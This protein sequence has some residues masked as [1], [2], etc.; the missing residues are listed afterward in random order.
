MFA[1]AIRDID[2]RLHKDDV[3]RRRRAALRAPLREAEA[4]ARRL[5]EFLLKGEHRVPA[6]LAQKIREF[7]QRQAPSMAPGGRSPAWTHGVL[8]LDL[9][10]DVQEHFRLQITS[11]APV[12]ASI[13]V[14][15]AASEAA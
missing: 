14:F 13:T 1:D 5:E 3:E 11:R 12:A 4:Y 8:L 10:F 6:D 2:E 9:L 15:G 7:V